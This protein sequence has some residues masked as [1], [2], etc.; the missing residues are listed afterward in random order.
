M[1]DVALD[2]IVARLAEALEM[3]GQSVSLPAAAVEAART[4][5][6]AVPASDKQRLAE[7][8]VAWAVKLERLAGTNAVAARIV[9]AELA[10]ELLGDEA[11][12]RDMFGKAGLGKDMAEAIG[13]R[14]EVRAPR[15]EDKKAAPAVKAARGLRKPDV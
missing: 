14:G 6:K 11:A 15:P 4:K 8:L 13:G 2:P 7:D 1:P 3:K 5:L 9:A 10:L 12:A